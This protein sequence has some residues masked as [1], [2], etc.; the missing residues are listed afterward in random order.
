MRKREKS[1]N[2]TEDS[3][4]GVSL[5]NGMRKRDFLVR[6]CGSTDFMLCL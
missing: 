3:S 1:T 5:R 2:N 6:L 4:G